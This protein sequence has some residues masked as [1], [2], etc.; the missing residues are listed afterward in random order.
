M[1]R[2]V[3]SRLRHARPA[4]GDTAAMSILGLC[5]AG[6]STSLR[7]EM[8]DFTTE[9]FGLARGD[10]DGVDADVFVLPDESSFAV[11]SGGGH[12]CDLPFP[13]LPG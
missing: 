4:P 5:F 2:A 1:I 12:G 11:T 6:S 13:R 7:A 9:V 10:I 3:R 8:T